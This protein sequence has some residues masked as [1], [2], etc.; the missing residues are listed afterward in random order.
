VIISL[1]LKRPTVAEP[2]PVDVDALG[3]VFAE[4]GLTR[5]DASWTTLEV[6]D[7]GRCDL[8]VP[9]WDD[10]E[11]LVE[12]YALVG[13]ISL[14]LAAALHR[15]AA[16]AGLLMI[17]ETSE[18]LVLVPDSAVAAEVDLADDTP[19]P[20]VCYGAVD[21]ERMLRHAIALELEADGANAEEPVLPDDSDRP[22]P[23]SE[24][25]WSALRAFRPN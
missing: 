20:V 19:H 7:G 5:D 12:L 24:L 3:E 9:G 15:I 2:V 16:A 18:P 25:L 10:D 17:T 13:E 6:D 14:E 21:L 11:P 1:T 4:L 8:Y 23:R 22:V